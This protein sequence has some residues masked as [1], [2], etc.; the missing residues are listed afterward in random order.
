MLF[1]LTSPAQSVST[2]FE[3][4]VKSD[5]SQLTQA[6]NEFLEHIV[7]VDAPGGG[8]YVAS[9]TYNGTTMVHDLLLGKYT[10]AG[11][12]VWTAQ[13]NI[14]GGGDVLVGGLSVDGSGNVLFTG[15]VDNGTNS[16][17]A[18]TVKF[19]SAGAEQ[20]HHTHNGS[21]NGYDSGTAVTSDA[22]GNV[23]VTGL[24]SQSTTSMDYL[25]LAYTPTGT[26]SWSQLFDGTGLVDAASFITESGGVLNVIGASQQAV[27]TWAVNAQKYNAS[28]GAVI[29]GGLVSLNI[30][31][32]E[33]NGFTTDDSGNIYVVGAREGSGHD[34]LTIKLA[35]DL[36]V[37]WEKVLDVDGGDDVAKAVAVDSSGNVYASGYATSA[38]QK[39]YI[40]LKYSSAG[41]FQWRK[42]Y[43]SGNKGEGAATDLAVDGAGNSFVTGHSMVGGNFDYYTIWYAPDGTEMW[44]GRF[45]SIYNKEDRAAV[46]QLDGEENLLVTGR[47]I[48]W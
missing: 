32:D 6:Q 2:Y 38:N 40:T 7:S 10:D 21:A 25:I 27:D 12:T 13:F 23:Y 35:P 17:D 47:R 9:S 3:D 20:W 42:Q 33:I 1:A 41:S 19:S 36:T 18:L 29:S 16:F 14:P 37:L 26:L 43:D 28:T 44:G 8:I 48:F 4:W 11:T 30:V 5:G 22:A 15:S 39:D 34:L 24:A 31:F 45:N 46:I